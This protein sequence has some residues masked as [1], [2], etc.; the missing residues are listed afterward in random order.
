MYV[1][2]NGDLSGGK[3]ARHVVL[4]FVAFVVIIGGWGTIRAGENCKL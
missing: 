2:E 1:K 4:A 3:I